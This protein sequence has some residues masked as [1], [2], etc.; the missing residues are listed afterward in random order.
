MSH[1]GRGGH[2]GGGLV[3]EPRPAF[4]SGCLRTVLIFIARAIFTP[5]AMARPSLLALALA[6]AACAPRTASAP[7]AP[8]ALSEGTLGVLVMAHGGGAEW[9]ASVQ[10]AVAPLA[11]QMPVEVA[12]GMADPM[13]LAD[14]IDRL[15]AAGVERVAVVRMFL[16]GES[17]WDQTVY[18][19]GISDTPPEQFLLMDHGGGHGNHGAAHDGDPEPV[20][21]GVTVA[22]HVEG[23]M[24]SPEAADIVAARAR[25]LAQDPERESVLVLAHGMGDE[26]ENDRVLEAME[27]ARSRT[28]AHGFAAVRVATLREDWP[29]ARA[30]S[31]REIRAFVQAESEAGRR[32]IVVPYRLSGFGPYAEVL[33]GLEFT[34]AEGLLPHPRMADWVRRTAAQVICEAGWTGA[35]MPCSGTATAPAGPR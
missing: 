33:D 21:D 1:P 18:L 20:A 10:A 35:P 17:F 34:P 31:E 5:R 9:D 7:A 22:T 6:F 25:A 14:G 11:E 28:A 26:G 32:V 16:S 30:R 19:L 27:D 12:F 29:E 8:A 4:Y 15:E 2:P 3:A 24:R 23:I 13:T